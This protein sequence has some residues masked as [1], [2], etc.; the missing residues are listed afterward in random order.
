MSCE[1]I[2]EPLISNKATAIAN[3]PG[4]GEAECKPAAR[5]TRRGFLRAAAGV[6]GVG[7]GA[8][9]YSWRW[10]THWLEVVDRP[11]PVANLPGRLR[12]AR[13]VQMSDLHIG[14]M[15]D[16]DY[17]LRTFKR[18]QDL[19][20]EIVVYT[21]DITTYSRNLFSHAGRMFP[22]LPLGSQATLGVLGNHDYGP[23]CTRPEVADRIVAMAGAAGVRILRNEVAEVDGLQVLGFDELWAGRFQPGRAMAKLQPHCAA[24]ALSHNPDTADKPGWGQYAGWILAGHTHGGQCKP[25]FLPPPLLPVRNRRYTAGEFALDGGRRMYINRGVG[26]TLPVRFNVRPEVTVFRLEPA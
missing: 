21:G 16:D 19:A 18:V 17:L 1:D 9:L 2:R 23:F 22:H 3:S 7:M 4:A 13:L 26:H 20:P 12:G 5:V 15:V 8:G 10:E 25:P 24:L 14:P 6:L 11:L